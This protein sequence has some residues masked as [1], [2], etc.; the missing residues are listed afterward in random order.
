MAAAQNMSIQPFDTYSNPE[1]LGP[2]WMRWK[3]SFKYFADTKWLIVAGAD[4]VV[5]RSTQRRSALLDYARP[6]VQEMFSTLPE[7]G[8]DDAF[9]AA[10]AALDNLFCTGRKCSVR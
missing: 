8:N 4:D 1:N 6:A 5:Q 7:R 2:R 9:D 3:E 10:V